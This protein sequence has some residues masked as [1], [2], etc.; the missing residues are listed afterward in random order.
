MGGIWLPANE[1]ECPLLWRHWFPA[2]TTTSVVS[3]AN[4]TGTL[5]NSDLELAAHVAA[6]DILASAYDIRETTVFALSDNTP[7]LSWAKQGSVSTDSVSAYLLRLHALH[8][9]QYRYLSQH[10][11]IP[12]KDNV[13]ADL[14]SRHWHLSDSDL[15]SLFDTHFPQKLPWRLCHLRPPRTSAINSALCKQRS[16]PDSL[17]NTLQPSSPLSKNGP[18]S[19]PPIP[20]PSTSTPTNPSSPGS[21]SSPKSTAITASPHAPVSDP[22]AIAQWRKPAASWPRRTPAWDTRILAA[23]PPAASTKPS[24]CSSL[25]G[26]VKTTHQRASVPS[27]SPCSASR[28]R[29]PEG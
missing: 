14:L 18:T 27:R 11:H 6:H 10:A 4:P 26:P 24:V 13:H 19:V 22:S 15:L 23:T 12:G 5:T 28:S 16:E 9:R 8:Q 1:S 25:T 21:S 29:A 3:L 2:S 7:M 17:L 20:V